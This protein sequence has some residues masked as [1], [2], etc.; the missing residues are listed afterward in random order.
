MMD[1]WMDGRMFS[2]LIRADCVILSLF[3][4][5]HAY[6]EDVHDVLYMRTMDI[7]LRHIFCIKYYQ[8][9]RR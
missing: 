6:F 7:V 4:F 5:F 2:G 1:G 3:M 9:I 8:Y